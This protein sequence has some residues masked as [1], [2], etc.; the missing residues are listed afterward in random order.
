MTEPL[1][2]VGQVIKKLDTLNSLLSTQTT[3]DHIFTFDGKPSQFR[4]WIK[5]VD[6][7]CIIDRLD[8]TT[9]AY[10]TSRGVVSDFISRI[11]IKAQTP[12]GIL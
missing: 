11:S 3:T 5:D 2:A 8:K 10:Q 6:K 9:V 1:E 7:F 12:T 4:K